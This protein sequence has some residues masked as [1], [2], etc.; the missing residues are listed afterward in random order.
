MASVLYYIPAV[1]TWAEV[2]TLGRGSLAVSAD[3]DDG[4]D[5]DHHLFLNYH[6]AKLKR[7]G[8]G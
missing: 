3:E 8:R 7:I 6:N 2:I 4:A 1:V 5:D